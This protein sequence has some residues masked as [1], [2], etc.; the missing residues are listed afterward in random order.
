MLSRDEEDAVMLEFERLAGVQSVQ[1]VV[2]LA[3]IMW[4]GFS[5]MSSF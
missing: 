2:E 4:N 5:C 3:R 1:V